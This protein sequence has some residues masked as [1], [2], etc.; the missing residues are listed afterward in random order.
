MGQ[1]NFEDSIM[2]AI[3]ISS[4]STRAGERTSNAENEPVSICS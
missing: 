2:G 4:A 1:G 3:G